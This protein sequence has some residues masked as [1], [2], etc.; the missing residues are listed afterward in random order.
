MKWYPSNL[1][2]IPTQYA[3][4]P[5]DEK[6]TRNDDPSL[7]SV[8]ENR[9]KI[10]VQRHLLLCILESFFALLLCPKSRSIGDKALHFCCCFNLI[11]LQRSVQVSSLDETLLQFWCYHW[12]RYY[13][14]S[15]V[16][17]I[18]YHHFPVK[19]RILKFIIALMLPFKTPVDGYV[20]VW[21]DLVFCR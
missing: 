13:L 18:P 1:N 4:K 10:A 21:R 3:S 2:K 15:D 19:D 14:L 12:Y 9:S 16:F 17:D 7:E 6:Y 11:R 20:L 5:H 8:V